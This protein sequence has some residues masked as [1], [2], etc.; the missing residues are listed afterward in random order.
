MLAGCAATGAA[1][2]ANDSQ[3]VSPDCHL[4]DVHTTLQQRA[5]AL[6]F[7]AAQRTVSPYVYRHTRTA[8]MMQLLMAATGDPH[9]VGRQPEEACGSGADD[10]LQAVEG[11]VAAAAVVAVRIALR[12]CRVTQQVSR[13]QI[14]CTDCASKPGCLQ[15]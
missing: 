15:A 5:G 12:H 13:R 4:A 8:P 6:A 10:R 11:G 9:R 1:A 7:T 3:W 2:D 14:L